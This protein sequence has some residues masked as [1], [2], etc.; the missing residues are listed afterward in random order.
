MWKPRSTSGLCLFGARRI[1]LGTQTPRIHL[2]HH[3][4]RH[5]T[6]AGEH[7][8]GLDRQFFRIDVALQFRGGLQAQQVLAIDLADHGALDVGTLADHLTLDHTGL[9][10]DHAATR[11]DG[12]FHP[13]VDADVAVRT[14]LAFD[15]GALHDA[16]DL[17]GAYGFCGLVHHW[18]RRFIISEHRHGRGRFNERL[19]RKYSRA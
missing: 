5:A 16:V 1:V 10:H 14:D 4:A 3:T 2:L 15:G 6:V 11:V 12:A 8:A 13:P 18:G 17:A 7:R 9:A 19:L